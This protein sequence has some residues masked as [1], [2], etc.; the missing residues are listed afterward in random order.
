[1]MILIEFDGVLVDVRAVYYAVHCRSA[2]DSGWSCLDEPTFWRLIR[3][4]GRHSG[5]LP[6]A[7]AGLVES[8]HARFESEIE[9][10]ENIAQFDS[11]PGCADV[12]R[13]LSRHGSCAG[14]TFG[15]N[16]DARRAVLESGKIGDVVDRLDGL[17]E[18]P[19]RRPGELTI[20][21]TGQPRTMVVAAGDALIRAAGQ[22]GL[23]CVGVSSG[24]C[25]ARRLHQAG[26]DV[27]Y[28]KLEEL[29]DS[30]E[31]GAPD[32]VRAG[33]LPPSAFEL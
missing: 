1:M 26:A 27:V 22:A 23:F 8:Y 20:L 21:A 18:D 24:Y 7:R 17:H 10:T 9:A 29:V 5:L 31:R 15:R 16:V 28:T 12:L 33:L 2:R 4:K 30:L 13:R 6:G 11:R 14:V 32:L 19:R 25:S 3:T